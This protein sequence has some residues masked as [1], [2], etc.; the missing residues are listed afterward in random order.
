[1]RNGLNL[2]YFK[3]LF[4]FLNHKY[5]YSKIFLFLLEIPLVQLRQTD[6]LSSFLLFSCY[7]LYRRSEIGISRGASFYTWHSNLSLSPHLSFSHSRFACH[8]WI[9]AA[10]RDLSTGRSPGFVLLSSDWVA[11]SHLPYLSHSYSSLCHQEYILFIQRA[12]L[13]VPKLSD[14]RGG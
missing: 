1:M 6:F 10:Y 14:G 12:C 7:I 4:S 9:F 11:P 13:L 5:P 8:S 2:E 3:T